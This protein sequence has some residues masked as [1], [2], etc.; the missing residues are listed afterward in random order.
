MDHSQHNHG[1]HGHDHNNHG[2]DHSNHDHGAPIDV[3]TVAS[4]IINAVMN[5]S[6]N[7]AD[8]PQMD[9]PHAGHAGHTGHGMGGM[10]SMAFHGGY[11]ETI[12]FTQ[13]QIN[14]LSGLLWSMLVIFIMGM[15]YEGLKYYREHLF[16]KNYNALQYRAVSVPKN[17]GPVDENGQ[18]VHMV[19]EVIHKEP[20]TIC[21][22]L[23][24]Y[25]T[26]LHLIQVTV[27]FMLMLIF[28]TFNT[29]LCLS[30][31]LGAGAG[32]FLFGYKKS[33]VVDVTEHCH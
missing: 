10:M 28:M 2:H 24:F 32:F 15:L 17:D 1:S 23:H 11:D 4:T 14:S 21:S 12:L 20:P 22:M 5:H 6:V 8:V 16:W 7:K 29:W 33:V 25:Q 9:D 30:V 31:V 3:T 27:S 26:I 19:G 18:V 13:W